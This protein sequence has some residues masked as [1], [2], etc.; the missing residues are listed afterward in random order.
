MQILVASAERRG[1]KS[2]HVWGMPFLTA[3]S[4]PLSWI[5]F[6]YIASEWTQ[7][8]TPPPT[9]PLLLHVSL[10][11]WSRDLVAVETCLHSRSLA[12]A[13]SSGSATLAFSRHV[14]MYTD[15]HAHKYSGFLLKQMGCW[16]TIHLMMMKIQRFIS[17]HQDKLFA[18]SMS[19]S[20]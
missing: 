11:R 13:V 15:T 10:L 17:W 8:R 12:M 3:T 1:G 6:C 2:V 7:Q 4:G 20:S 18:V 16:H 14:T 19:N 9:V 5:R